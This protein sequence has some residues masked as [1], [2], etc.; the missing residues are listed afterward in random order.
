MSMDRFRLQKT[1]TKTREKGDLAEAQ[2]ALPARPR[3]SGRL[4]LGSAKTGERK[5]GV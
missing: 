5:V 1:K 4:M 3:L 2:R